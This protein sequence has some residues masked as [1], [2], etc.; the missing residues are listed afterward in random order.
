[1]S[2]VD[3]ASWIVLGSQASPFDPKPQIFQLG[4]AFVLFI[5][6]LKHTY[7]FF[8]FF[9]SW[10]NAL[11]DFCLMFSMFVLFLVLRKLLDFIL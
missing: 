7:V 10:N 8:L 3:L 9:L 1:M 2:W 11:S 5:T 6:P 4:N